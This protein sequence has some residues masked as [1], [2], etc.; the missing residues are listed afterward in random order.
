M[1]LDYQ[2]TLEHSS[3]R[4]RVN[5]GANTLEMRHS[6]VHAFEE[7]NILGGYSA[8]SRMTD[9]RTAW[10]AVSM[11][12]RDMTAFLTGRGFS[13]DEWASM[14]GW[15]VFRNVRLGHEDASLAPAELGAILPASG[16]RTRLKGGLRLGNGRY[17]VDGAPDLF[18][19]ASPLEGEGP[20]EIVPDQS[21]ILRCL[22]H[23][24]ATPVIGG[25]PVRINRN[26]PPD[27]TVSISPPG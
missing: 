27:E 12:R 9:G 13:G 25:G 20:L 7:D 10:L 14:P 23:H 16:L 5:L 26:R 6:P 22:P 21:Y 8:T 4:E 24:A 2:L 11:R 17:L 18:V 1:H 15:L 19:P 3:R